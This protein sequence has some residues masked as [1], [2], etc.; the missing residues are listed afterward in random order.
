M[1]CQDPRPGLRI[2]EIGSYAEPG[3]EAMRRRTKIREFGSYAEPDRDP[4]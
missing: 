3:P 2:R 1:S 4:G